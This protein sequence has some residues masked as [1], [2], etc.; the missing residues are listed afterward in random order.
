M[1]LWAKIGAT[2]AGCAV[3]C[4][5]LGWIVLTDA[6][7]ETLTVTNEVENAD[8]TVTFDGGEPAWRFSVAA[9][10]T[11][12]KFFL[13]GIPVIKSTTCQSTQPVTPIVLRHEPACTGSSR[14][15]E[16]LLSGGAGCGP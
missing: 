15:Y 4:G 8:C 12:E 13:F 5:C 3:C 16:I 9:D 7:P 10:R 14:P 1:W 6:P 11:T 2:L